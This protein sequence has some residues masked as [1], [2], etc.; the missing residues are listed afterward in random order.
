M[1]GKVV[2]EAGVT[3][4]ESADIKAA[5]SLSKKKFVCKCSLRGNLYLARERQL[6]FRIEGQFCGKIITRD[7]EK[8][9]LRFVKTSPADREFDS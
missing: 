8:C 9:N 6:K 5:L 3:H 1:L 2:L 4:L 7:S